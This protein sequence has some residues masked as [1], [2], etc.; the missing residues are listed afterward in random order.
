I[1]CI[2]S[3]AIAARCPAHSVS[4]IITSLL[5]RSSFFCTSPW[6]FSTPALPRAP[7]SAPRLTW[8]L[9][10]FT[11]VATALSSPEKSPVEPGCRCS[12]SMV[13][14]VSVLRSSRT[15][16]CLSRNAGDAAGTSPWGIRGDRTLRRRLAGAPAV[17][18]EL[19]LRGGDVARRPAP[20]A[21]R[22]LDQGTPERERQP[23]WRRGVRRGAGVDGGQ[24][25]ACPR[26]GLTAGQECDAR[27]GGRHGRGQDLQR[28]MS[29][30][31]R[32]G[33]VRTTRA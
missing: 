21:Q 12:D 22:V 3:D 17:A 29:D 16:A 4:P 14:R 33:L 25:R 5:M 31:R 23:P 6:T 20:G 10:I 9:M 8:L 28:A 7:T 11:A 2:S 1:S 18:R 30:F 19:V 27:N 26:V 24:V 32:P 13:Y 15:L